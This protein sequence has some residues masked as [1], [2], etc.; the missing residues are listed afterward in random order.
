VWGETRV[1]GANEG[2]RSEWEEVGEGGREV[3]A[4]GVWQ[5]G[6]RGAEKGGGGG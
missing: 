3:D 4:E 1:R 2:E 6:G 5:R